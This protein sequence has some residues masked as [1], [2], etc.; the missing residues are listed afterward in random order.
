MVFYCTKFHETNFFYYIV[1]LWPEKFGYMR[2]EIDQ[3]LRDWPITNN[4]RLF[5][6]LK[7]FL[8]LLKFKILVFKMLRVSNNQIILSKIIFILN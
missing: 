1:K 3:I 2:N 7:K 5:K 4:Q 6:Y 8:N